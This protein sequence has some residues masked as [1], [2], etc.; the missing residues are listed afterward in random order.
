M[1]QV[2]VISLSILY[3][4]TFKLNRSHILYIFV[5]T[6]DNTIYCCIISL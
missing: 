6:Y 4:L 5:N 3:A 1:G 2:A